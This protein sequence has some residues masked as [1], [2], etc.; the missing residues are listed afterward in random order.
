MTSPHVPEPGMEVVTNDGTVLGHVKDVS[1][2]AQCFRVD[3][4]HAP[5]L[6]VPHNYIQRAAEGSLI[7]RV[8]KHQVSYLGWELR[9]KSYGE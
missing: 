9:P 7:L 4:R 1:H 6:Y 3:C 2:T 5:D 8:S